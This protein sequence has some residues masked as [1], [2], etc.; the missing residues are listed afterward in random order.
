MGARFRQA[1]AC[2]LC[3]LFSDLLLNAT[4]PAG[5]AAVTACIDAD[6]RRIFTQFGCPSGAEA[7][8]LP[9]GDGNLTVVRTASLSSSERAALERLERRLAADRERRARLYRQSA[10]RSS[11][12]RAEA[13]QRCDAAKDALAALAET[14][15]KG[16]TA[17]EDRRYDAEE[18]RW[19]AV[20]K[21][22]C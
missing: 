11:A 1:A 13:R 22:D 17:T 20:R 4:C 19:N 7:S 12:E 18:S 6:G 9:G 14:R 2:C 3:L 5:H 16:Y 21:A 10:A 8:A 15:R